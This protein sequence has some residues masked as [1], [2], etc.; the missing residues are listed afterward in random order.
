M[1]TG[2]GPP[3]STVPRAH[4]QG[5]HMLRR[6]LPFVLLLSFAV[7]ACGDDDSVF[8]LEAGMCFNDPGTL[9]QV[10]SVET[11]DCSEPHDNEIYLV[12]RYPGGGDYPGDAVIEQ[13]AFT[14]CFDAFEPF[15]GLAYE[16]SRFDI[17]GLWPSRESWTD[18]GD[19]EIICAVYDIDGAKLTG[20]VRGVGE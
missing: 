7:G 11:V 19:R 2:P 4:E 18:L 10:Y 13:A 15:I 3:S 1:S 16:Y 17:T 5:D 8:E 20:S 6:L 12:T 9:E 14:A